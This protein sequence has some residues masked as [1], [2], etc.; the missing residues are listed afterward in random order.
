MN[1]LLL[2]TDTLNNSDLT[3]TDGH[4]DKQRSTQKR[5]N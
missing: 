3:I 4:Y 5:K 1:I 2:S